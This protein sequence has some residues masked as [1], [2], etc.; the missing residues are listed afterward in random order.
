[1]KLMSISKVSPTELDSL[2][3]MIPR[4]EQPRE[5]LPN[6]A[7]CRE[8]LT[9]RFG[10]SVRLRDDL[11]AVSLIG[12]GINQTFANLRRT[13]ALLTDAGIRPAAWHT[14]SFRITALVQ[15]G[16]V[17]DAVRLLHREFIEEEG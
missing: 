2:P 15:A 5:F 16:Q 6:P 14:S 9:G 1:M 13:R 10:D 17:N 11:G 8:R 3:G 12:A 4:L 7:G